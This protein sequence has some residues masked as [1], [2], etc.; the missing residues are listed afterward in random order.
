MGHC[1]GV[2]VF[3][4]LFVSVEVLLFFL[5]P[6]PCELMSTAKSRRKVVVQNMCRC[7]RHQC[8]QRSAVVETR[9]VAVVQQA[10]L[11]LG[12]EKRFE[13]A[14]TNCSCGQH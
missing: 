13:M 1:V 5:R 6:A 9:P 3:V 12:P 2:V 4:L 10:S 14:I 7:P 11:A 8:Y